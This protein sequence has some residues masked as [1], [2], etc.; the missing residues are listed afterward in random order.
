M[1]RLRRLLGRAEM[2][3]DEVQ[4]LRGLARQI[5]WVSGRAGLPPAPERDER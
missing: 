4:L 5:L 2:S 1:R 3:P